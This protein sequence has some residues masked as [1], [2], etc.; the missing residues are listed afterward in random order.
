ML[1][2][3]RTFLKIVGWVSG[4]ALLPSVSRALGP[5]SQIQIMQIVY[6]GGNWRPRPTALRRLAWEIHKRTAINAA[7]EPAEVKPTNKALS[8]SPL[9][10]LSGDRGFHEWDQAS[11]KACTR[12]LRLGGT[13]I[14]DPAYTPEGDRAGFENSV[15]TLIAAVLPENKAKRIGTDHVLY[16]SFYQLDRPVGRIEGPPFL[17]GHELD[18]R[19]A[20][21]RSRHDLGGAWAR[22]NLGNWE[23]TVLPGG[24]RQR[25]AA[26]R[27]GVNIIM[28]VLCLDYKDEEPHRRF[29]KMAVGD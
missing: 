28:Y 22:D 23:H 11:I 14:V 12:F 29:G 26:F 7:L 2:N 10:Y 15:D 27:L 18:Q 3:R 25:E 17:I 8:E 20:I 5:S 16:R 13:L 1:A 6:P 24:E 19:L 9:V 21:I 4:G